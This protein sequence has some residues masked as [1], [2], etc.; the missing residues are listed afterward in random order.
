MLKKNREKV[1]ASFVEWK[2]AWSP[3]GTVVWGAI[4]KTIGDV[5]VTVLV[6]GKP[7]SGVVNAYSF[8]L[9]ARIIT[10]P[11]VKP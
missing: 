2:T 4:F 6:D 3:S 10:F 1:L 11:D 9:K 8:A 7:A 5:S